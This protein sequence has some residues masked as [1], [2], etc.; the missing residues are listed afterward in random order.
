MG[1][2]VGLYIS[3][4]QRNNVGLTSTDIGLSYLTGGH[5]STAEGC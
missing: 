4:H 2:K 1:Q 5:C 3:L